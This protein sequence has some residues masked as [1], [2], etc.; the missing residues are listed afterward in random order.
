METVIYCLVCERH[1]DVKTS[2]SDYVNYFT[3]THKCL[4]ILNNHL[5]DTKIQG[6]FKKQD[7]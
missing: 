2:L 1:S 5:V 3:L 6:T 4:R 7:I